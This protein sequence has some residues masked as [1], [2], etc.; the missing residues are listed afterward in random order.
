[1]TRTYQLRRRA[2]RQED[3]RRRIVDAA[4]ALHTTVGPARTTDVAVAERAGVTRR[5]FYR[6]FPDGLSLWRACT[7]HGLEKWPPPDP[8][9]WR[10]IVDPAQRL[11]LAL[12]ELY[13]YY[14]EVGAGLATIFR[15]FPLLPRELHGVPSR[16][17]VLRAMPAALLEGWAVQGRRRAVLTTALAHATAVTTWQSLVQ[18][19]DLADTEAVELLEA[20]VLAAA[21]YRGQ[22]SPM[23]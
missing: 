18:L 13:A 6:H 7:R 20:M 4:V 10:Q 3:T 2:E 22:G 17:D 14:R 16:M 19:Q 23:P 8:E 1:M 5:T 12:N 15:D 21:D 11:P 9:R